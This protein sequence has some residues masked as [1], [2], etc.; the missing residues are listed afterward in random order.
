MI[1]LLH[2]GVRHLDAGTVLR[3]WTWDPFVLPL[4]ALSAALYVIGLDRLWARAGIGQGIRRWEAAC[5]GLGWLGL[6]VA[7]VSPLDSLG[8]VLFSAHMAQHEVL[9]LIAAPLMVLGKPLAVMLWAL[10]RPARERA[11]R[12]TQAPAFAASWRRL[13]A[14]LTVWVLHGLALWL[15]HLPDLYQRTLDDD[16]VHALQHL[17]FFLTATLFWW[18]LAHGR[19]GRLGYGAAVLYVFTTSMHSGVLGALLTFAPR[20]WYPIYQA[21]TSRWG[22]SPLEDQQLAGLIMW[23][24]AGLVFVLL[25]LAL[26]AAWMGEAERRVAHTRSETLLRALEQG[27]TGHGA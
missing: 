23:V 1:L 3:W 12:W 21:R 16:L 25:G 5:F 24:P 22:L 14:P 8:D 10:P 17:S 6:V 9:I 18:S 7:L 11:G 13:T 19:F 15:W 27:R 20:L 26:F 2:G 4:L